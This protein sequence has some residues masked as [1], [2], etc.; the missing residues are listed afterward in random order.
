MTLDLLD[1]MMRFGRPGMRLCI[2]TDGAKIL[3]KAGQKPSPASALLVRQLHEASYLATAVGT[4]TDD[5]VACREWILSAEG[6]SALRAA[7]MRSTP[8]PPAGNEAPDANSRKRP[9]NRRQGRLANLTAA[10]NS[11]TATAAPP[12]RPLG[13]RTVVEQL[14][15][16]RD[17][18]GLPLINADQFSA[19]MRFASDFAVANMQQRVTARWAADAVPSRHRRGA[20]G[21]GVEISDAAAAAQARVRLALAAVGGRLA[22]VVMDVCV[23][24][25]GLE[26]IEARQGWPVRSARIVLQLALDSLARHYGMGVPQHRPAGIRHW[27]EQNFRPSAEAWRQS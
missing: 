3:G 25:L 11:G 6:R 13:Q 23:F 19:A 24:D 1:L 22:D 8:V 26:A 18:R 17:A 5:G 9:R 27:G 16:R 7:L 10:A 12:V 20:P 2:G 15:A 14:H 21:A 4:T